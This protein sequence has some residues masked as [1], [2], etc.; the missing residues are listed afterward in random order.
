MGLVDRSSR[1]DCIVI[2]VEIVV[3]VVVREE[4]GGRQRR[5][6]GV[7]MFVISRNPPLLVGIACMR[8]YSGGRGA[9]MPR[10]HTHRQLHARSTRDDSTVVHPP[11]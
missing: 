6:R 4:V 7:Y 11:F 1:G 8:V 10:P 2:V 5:R 9:T 3:D